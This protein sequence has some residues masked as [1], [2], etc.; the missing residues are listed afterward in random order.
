MQIRA[1]GQLKAQMNSTHA[2]ATASTHPTFA[3]CMA[4]P[5]AAA[6]KESPQ[7]STGTPATEARDEY[8][9]KVFNKKLPK[10]NMFAGKNKGF[11]A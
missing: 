3:T 6:G 1:Q 2:R 7:T 10:P 5:I 11:K 9:C 8:C 4:L